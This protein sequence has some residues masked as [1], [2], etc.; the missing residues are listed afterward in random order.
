MM[1]FDMTGPELWLFRDAA[2]SPVQGGPARLQPIESRVIFGF[3]ARDILLH[4][5]ARGDRSDPLA[6]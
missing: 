4:A 3:E 6:A 5:L 1:A 2:C